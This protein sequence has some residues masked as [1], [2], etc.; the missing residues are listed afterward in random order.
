MRSDT[1]LAH[2]LPRVKQRNGTKVSWAALHGQFGNDVKDK[3]T[4][5]RNFK[6]ALRKAVSVYPAAKVE[7]EDGGLRLRSSAPPI[8]RKL[9]GG[10]K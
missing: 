5:R 2:R 3:K 6:I 8:R 4:F 7:Q 1:W 9:V 10:K